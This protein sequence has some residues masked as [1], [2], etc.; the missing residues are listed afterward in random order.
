MVMGSCERAPSHVVIL[1]VE[2]MHRMYSVDTILALYRFEAVLVPY[3][4]SE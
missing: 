1:V 4:C 2:M 3:L